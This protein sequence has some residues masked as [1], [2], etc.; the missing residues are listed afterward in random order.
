[1]P[2]L[3]VTVTPQELLALE[4][5]GRELGYLDKPYAQRLLEYFAQCAFAGYNRPGSWERD[6]LHQATGWFLPK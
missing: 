2:D 3:T 5:I 1:M 4:E 6:W